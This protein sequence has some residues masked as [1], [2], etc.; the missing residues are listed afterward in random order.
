MNTADLAQQNIILRGLVGSTVHGLALEGQDDRDEMGVFIEP[1]EYVLGLGHV[2]QWTFRT[3]PDGVRSG[4]GDLDLTVYA[5]RKYARLASSG[6]PTILLLF[7]L[8]ASAVLYAN[9][10]GHRLLDSRDLFVSRQA[11][12]AFLGYLRAQRQRGMGSE[13]ARRHGKPRADLVEQYGYDTKYA[14]HMLRL[15]YQGVEFL[16]TGRLTLPMPEP[17]RSHLMGVRTGKI[18]ENHV[19]T[20]AG[21]LERRLE[22]LLD[23]SPLPASPDRAAIDRFLIEMQ[24]QWWVWTRD[25]DDQTGGTS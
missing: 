16:E 6:N 21:E 4:H 19:L 20:E 3:Q 25:R 18:S 17:V 1:Q 22:D 24:E 10:W 23:T 12:R 7:H 13:R 15:G 2:E 11:G 14:M 5:L 8:P 9:D